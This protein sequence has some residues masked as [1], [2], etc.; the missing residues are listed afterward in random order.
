MLEELLNFIVDVILSFWIDNFRAFILFLNSSWGSFSWWCTFTFS[1]RSFSSFASL[2][3]CILLILLSYSFSLLI[4]N[5]KLFLC[6]SF[7][8]LLFLF[9]NELLSRDLSF[10]SSAW[11]IS[12]PLSLKSLLSVFL[13]GVF[14]DSQCLTAVDFDLPSNL[15]RIIVSSF[16]FRPFMQVEQSLNH[17]VVLNFRIWIRTLFNSLRESIIASEHNMTNCD[18]VIPSAAMN[19]LTIVKDIDSE[20][21]R[22]HSFNI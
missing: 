8:C 22:S 15:G 18:L 17:V 12:F 9:E 2:S 6:Q 7:S 13:I 3:C 5:S 16:T 19:F 1:G 21:F 14:N 4:D 10:F 11:F 20:V